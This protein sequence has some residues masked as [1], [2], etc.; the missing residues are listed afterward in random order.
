MS[1]G[2]IEEINK[3]IHRPENQRTALTGQRQVKGTYQSA[4]HFPLES[5]MITRRT[6]KL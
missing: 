3:S 1:N 6:S 5:Q 2:E 4:S